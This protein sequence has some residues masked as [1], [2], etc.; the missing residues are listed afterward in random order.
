MN[1]K[2][3]LAGLALIAWLG[4]PRPANAVLGSEVEMYNDDYTLSCF[5]E[6][7]KLE[8]ACNFDRCHVDKV[9]QSGKEVSPLS[10]DLPDWLLLP[11]GCEYCKAKPK[12]Q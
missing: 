11:K 8:I 7:L 4:A 9:Y 10:V 6:G 3:G 1:N 2:L 12:Y 5:Y